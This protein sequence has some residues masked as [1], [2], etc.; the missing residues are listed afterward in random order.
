MRFGRILA[1][2]LAISF[3]IESYGAVNVTASR[4]YVDQ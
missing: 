2:I 3:A 4:D 1:V